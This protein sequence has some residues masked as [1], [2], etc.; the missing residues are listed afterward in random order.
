MGESLFY[1][2]VGEALSKPQPKI[3]VLCGSTRFSRAFHDANLRETLSGNIV[4]TVGCDTK[5]DDALGLDASA[6]VSLDL[7]HLQKI[8]L[9]DEV[10]VLN[11]RGYIGASTAREI[12]YAALLGKPVR[13]LEPSLVRDA[14]VSCGV[15]Y[16]WPEEEKWVLY[17]R[18]LS[19]PC[20][21]SWEYVY[22]VCCVNS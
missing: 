9:A 1:H 19:M 16:V 8:N 4:L 12:A 15:L 22:P 21:C 17:R 3:V 11:V 6:K 18:S 5:S 10:L 14:C 7:L 2:L 13:F 20:G